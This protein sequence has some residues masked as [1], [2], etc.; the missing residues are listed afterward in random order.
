[1]VK[2]EKAIKEP[3]KKAS[4]VK[5]WDNRNNCEDFVESTVIKWYNDIYYGI[6]Y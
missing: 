3:L 1:M 6:Y 5:H 4:N 2:L